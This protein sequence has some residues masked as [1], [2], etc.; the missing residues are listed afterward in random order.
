[1]RLCARAPAGA[2]SHHSA[3]ILLS[4]CCAYNSRA[5]TV[6]GFRQ[7]VRSGHCEAP[8]RGHGSETV[9]TGREHHRVWTTEETAMHAS[10]TSRYVARL[11]LTGLF[12][13]ILSPQAHAWGDKGHRLV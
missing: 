7:S 11:F 5:M 9:G 1:M 13:C 10:I 8:A 2:T 12:L 4:S 3:I 6:C